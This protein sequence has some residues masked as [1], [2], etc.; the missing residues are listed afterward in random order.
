MRL[1]ARRGAAAVTIRDIAAEAG[2]SPSLVIHH[3]G[4]KQGLREAVDNRAIAL[5]N[6]F[7]HRAHGRFRWR[8]RARHWRQRSPASS[9]E[10]RCSRGTCDA[11]SSTVVSLPR[12]S[13]GVLLRGGALGLCNP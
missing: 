8:G 13:F 1:F 9:N 7:G 12:P 6:A 3:Y 5:V 10:I 11:S 4:S 2:V